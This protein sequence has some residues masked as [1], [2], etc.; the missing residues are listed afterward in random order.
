M[1][2]YLIRHGEAEGNLYRRMQ[3][4]FNS[5]LTALGR[6]QIACL[7][8]R[9]RDIRL[10][11]VYSSDLYRAME[12]AA[13][14]CRPRSLPLFTDRRL[15]EVHVGPWEDQTFGNMAEDYP[16]EM[17]VFSADPPHWRLEGA[18]TFEGLSRRAIAA[19]LDIV[20]RHDGGT[21]AVCGHGYLINSI[22][23]GLFDGFDHPEKIGR[24]TNTA[25]SR[26]C[27]E[28]GRFYE[29]YR[30]DS[31][32]LPPALQSV[33]R[34]NMVIR[35]MAPDAVEEYIRYRS[36]AWQVVYGS[37][38]GFDGPGFWLDAQRTMGPDPEAMAVGYLDRR[39]AGMIQL[40]PDR[41][42]HKGVG[43]IPF[44]Y[45]REPYRYQGLGIELIGHAVSFYRRRGRT[46]LQLSVAPTNESALRFYRRYGFTQVK[47]QRGRFGHLLLMEKDISLPKAPSGVKII[48]VASKEAP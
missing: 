26:L 43:Y 46:K 35:P 36:D 23:S 9:F 37:L 6:K 40:N 5:D 19:L 47:K 45:L 12:T 13:A 48:P 2:V 41:D 20:R 14:L 11:A 32:H 4:Q 17:Q 18:D 33:L 22:L 38:Q 31:S 25:V 39:P 24:S 8:E 44:L 34:R 29:E 42:S 1:T 10:D 21:V 27:W 16:L 7:Q 15:R 30:H 3:G 28:N